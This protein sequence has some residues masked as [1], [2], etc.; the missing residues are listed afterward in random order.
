M[1]VISK[2]SDMPEQ[3]PF[4]DHSITEGTDTKRIK[5]VSVNVW[6]NEKRQICAFQG[7]YTDGKDFF[8]G[9]KTSSINGD[10]EK[11]VLEVDEGDYIKNIMGSFSKKGAIEF[12]AFYSA[13]GKARQFGK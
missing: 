5:I 8:I 7:I 13:K 2:G 4:D 10:M 12:L 6:F 11:E 9:S 1:R 3:A